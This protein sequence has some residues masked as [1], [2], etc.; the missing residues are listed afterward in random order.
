MTN[1]GKFDTL[2]IAFWDRH[3]E[4]YFC[5]IRDFHAVP[6]DGGLNE[7]VRDIRWM[8]SND[9][10]TWTTPIPLDFGESEDYP[11]YTNVVQPYYRGDHMF[12]GFPSRYVER[13][14]WTPNFEQLPGVDRRRA[15]I[16]RLPRYGLAVTDCVFMSSRDG[17]RWKRWDDSRKPSASSPIRHRVI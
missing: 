7:G 16:K 1:C 15:R 14:A 5:Y 6:A 8:A 12:V 10:K 4:Q 2:N 13:K 17:K 3:T 11:L 9:F